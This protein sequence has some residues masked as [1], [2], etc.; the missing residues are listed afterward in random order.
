MLPTTTIA[1][2]VAFVAICIATDV[3]TRRIPNL[4]CG[5]GMVTGLALNT[6][7]GGSA[8]L[9][10]SATGLLVAV[11]LLLFPFAM[12][13]LGGGDVKMMG[14]IGAMLGPRTT[15]EGLIV[16]MVL[17]GAIMMAHLV[18]RHRLRE[19]VV[20]VGTM[21]TASVLGGSLEPLRVSAAQPGAIALP[22][23]IPLGLGTIAVLALSGTLGL[24]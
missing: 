9:L 15:L 6:F 11:A 2:T 24:V 22:Y 10:A 18:R 14:A 1:V 17:G 5:L 19:T 21:A 13:G 20:N 3:R 4:V 7:S 12:G 16:G 8:G 23:S